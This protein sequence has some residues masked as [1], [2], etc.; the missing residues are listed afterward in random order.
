MGRA[1]SRSRELSVGV[2]LFFEARFGS[3]D[4][5]GGSCLENLGKFK[6]GA[7]G[8]TLDTTF[9]Q[10]YIGSIEASF[11]REF[12]LRKTALETHFSKRLSERPF[13]AGSWM[14]VAAA[15]LCQ[16]PHAAMLATIVPRIIVRIWGAL[17]RLPSPRGEISHMEKTPEGRMPVFGSARA[18]S[19]FRLCWREQRGTSSSG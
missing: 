4:D 16:Q 5:L 6:H 19:V 8:R 11:E 2:C 13:R 12:F 15:L 1:G 9:E 3:A 7:E 14:N 18:S 10:A 17:N